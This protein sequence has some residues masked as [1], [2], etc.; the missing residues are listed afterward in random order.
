MWTMIH[1]L[2]MKAYSVDLLRVALILTHL[3]H[4]G[5][6]S[7]VTLSWNRLSS[8]IMRYGSTTLK[9][10]ENRAQLLHRLLGVEVSKAIICRAI[11]RLGYTRK[12]QWVRVRE[13]FF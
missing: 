1:P 5:T 6:T 8:C 3:R 9:S 2:V 10:T 12:N 13:E 4:A 7:R 11:R